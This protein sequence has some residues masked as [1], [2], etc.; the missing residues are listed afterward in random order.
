MR[1]VFRFSFER[2]SH[3]LLVICVVVPV[4]GILISIVIPGLWRRWFP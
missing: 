3:R 4:L 2:E 1:K